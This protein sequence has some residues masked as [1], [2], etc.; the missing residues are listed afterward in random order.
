MSSECHLVLQAFID[1]FRFNAKR[2]SL[3]MLLEQ[4]C[5]NSSLHGREP[6]AEHTRCCPSQ[7]TWA[8]S[9]LSLRNLPATS[10]PAKWRSIHPQM[11]PVV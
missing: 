4:H 9:S 7:Q 10:L 6:L 2:V 11:L 3:P 8:F 1:K 5:L